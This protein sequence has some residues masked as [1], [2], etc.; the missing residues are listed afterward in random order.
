[1]SQQQ[2]LKQKTVRGL[3]WSAIERLS[4]QVI[5]FALALILARL[6]TP[7]DYGVLAI[8]MVFVTVAGLMVD[9]GF[10]NALIRKTDCTDVDRS[11]VFYFNLVVSALMYAIIYFAAPFLASFYENSELTPLIRCASVVVMINSLCIVQQ[12]TLTSRID[13]KKQTVISLSSSIVSGLLGITLAYQGYGVWALVAQTITQYSMRALMLWIV[14]RWRPLLVFSRESFNDLFGYS[15]KLMFSN[16][17]VAG[18]RE[19]LQLLMGKFF[20]VASLGHYNYANKLGSFLPITISMSIQRVLFPAFSQIQDKDEQLAENFRKS[21]VL[22]MSFIFPLMLSTSALAEPIINILL[23]KE[24]LPTVPLLRFMAITMAIWPL[25]LFN[26]NILWVKKRSDLSLR[27]EMINIVFRLGIVFAM[28]QTGI[29]WVSIALCIAEFLNYLVYAKVIERVCSHGLVKQLQDLVYPFFAAALSSYSAYYFL[30]PQFE[31]NFIKLL[32]S[33]PS[34]ILIYATLLLI[35][36][37][38]EVNLIWSLLNKKL[39]KQ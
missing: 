34:I 31:N 15:S 21:L 2:T 35:R 4:G 10:A 22:T 28:Y 19:V 25:L 8:V 12:A 18:G 29:L 5:S 17:I 14:V 23:T 1:M 20:S 38:Y 39:N 11:T 7:E 6:V 32:I 3:V 37:G 33:V 26:M 9:A 13:F 27:L 24:W 36:R 30:L 16:L